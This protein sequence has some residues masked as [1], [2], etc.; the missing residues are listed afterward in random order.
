M[1]K[2][3]EYQR[4]V[5]EGQEAEKQVN[6]THYAALEAGREVAKLMKKYQLEL[7]MSPQ[8]AVQKV[9]ADH[10]DL[11]QSYMAQT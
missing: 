1:S 3:T 4:L 11:W 6:E 9:R 7:K 2:P 8:E 5:R 10:G